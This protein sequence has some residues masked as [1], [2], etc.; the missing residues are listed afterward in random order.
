MHKSICYSTIFLP[1]N[2]IFCTKIIHSTYIT[3]MKNKLKTKYNLPVAVCLVV[4]IIIGSG[5]FFKAIDVLNYTSG[6]LAQGIIA[7]LAS[8]F[9]MLSCAFML[10]K[11]ASKY[12]RCGGIVDYAEA[13]CG[14]DY[15]YY[16]GWFMA[17]IYCPTMVSFLAYA[18]AKFICILLGFS[19]NGGACL[20]IA[21]T[22]VVL[23]F[24]LNA[25]APKLSGKF[26]I[27]TT[28]IKLIPLILMAVVGIIFGL[29]NGTTVQNISQTVS[30][31]AGGGLFKAIVATS[32]AYEG[33]IVATSINAELKNSKRNLPLALFWGSLATMVIYILYFLGLY[34]SANISVLQSNGVNAGFVNIFGGVAGTILGVFAVIC[35]LGTLNGLT[36]GGARALYALS[37]RN[38]GPL[39]YKFSQVDS[40]TN[41]P[42]NSCF[43]GLVMTSVWL[44]Y[45]YGAMLSPTKWFGVF[46]FDSCDLP[47][48]T[49]YAMYIPLF[50]SFIKKETKENKFFR[51]IV[52]IL[53]IISCLF[54]IFSAIMGHGVF[55]YQKA[56]E[57]G[58]FSFPVLFYLIIFAIIMVIGAL[59]DIPRKKN[60]TKNNLKITLNNT[61]PNINNTNLD[62]NQ[63]DNNN[64]TNENDTKNSDKLTKNNY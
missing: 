44:L 31:V 52:P 14:Q 20:V 60:L 58:Q 56:K 13:M 29:C 33:W 9:V 53:A 39:P 47:V 34:G 46:S 49:I 62:G 1:N 4:G 32:F 8:G 41:M 61:P 26:Q 7:W 59:F 21:G 50:V 48:I 42:A 17:T 30:S 35:C 25:L 16:V 19:S 15:A 64:K 37:S 22:L 6:N 55:E 24:A 11:L 18:S 51:Y 63:L 40:S 38:R 10:G 28:I 2:W 12:Q 23:S 54:M 3:D 45:Y 5:A 27:S 57:V 43:F 36:V